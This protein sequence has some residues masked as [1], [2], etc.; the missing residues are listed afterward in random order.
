MGFTKEMVVVYPQDVGKGRV[1][2]S[3]HVRNLKLDA[4]CCSR[5]DVPLLHLPRILALINSAISMKNEE[6]FEHL[7]TG[8]SIN[9]IMIRI[10][11][12]TGK[13]I[14][15]FIALERFILSKF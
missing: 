15:A 7:D 14:F 2:L 10:F 11:L 3:G 5:W 13:W 12:F 9:L 1:R 8:M 6:S 4:D